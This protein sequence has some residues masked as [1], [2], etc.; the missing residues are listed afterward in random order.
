MTGANGML[1][2]NKLFSEE[3]LCK[4]ISLL[5]FYSLL[6]EV[7]WVLFSLEE[8]RS[9]SDNGLMPSF[10]NCKT[11]AWLCGASGSKG[12]GSQ[13]FPSRHR[14]GFYNNE[15]R[16]ECHFCI[17]LLNW[18]HFLKMTFKLE[19]WEFAFQSHPLALILLNSWGSSYVDFSVLLFPHMWL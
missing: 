19:L 4:S 7:E 10:V 9:Y 8:V 15:T 12:G 11:F 17:W 3:C 2:E 18:P 14:L 6:T 5:N 1:K 13:C 16:Q